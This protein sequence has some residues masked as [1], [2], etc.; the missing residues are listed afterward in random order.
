METISSS[1]SAIMYFN[2]DLLF[3]LWI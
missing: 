3:K 1:I 2:P